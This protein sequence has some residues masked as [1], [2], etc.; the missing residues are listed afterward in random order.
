MLETYIRRFTT[1]SR[2]AL[3][4]ASNPYKAKRPWPPDFTKLSQ[5]HQFQLERRYR[6]RSQ[7]KWARPGWTKFTTLAQWGTISF[8]VVY[9][10]L[11]LNWG[12]NAIV[13]DKIR[14][15]YAG[16][17]Q[18]VWTKNPNEH[19]TPASRQQEASKS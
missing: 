6:R 13:F 12:G 2:L 1:S 8:V 15:W 17:G 4:A 18:E 5:K 14:A 9:A 19:Q 10:V 3:D 11:F 7:M 16:L